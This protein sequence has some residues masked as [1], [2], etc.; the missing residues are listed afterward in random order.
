MSTE[1]AE[2]YSDLL[3]GLAGFSGRAVL[4]RHFSVGVGESEVQLLTDLGKQTGAIVDQ[5]PEVLPEAVRT[6][7]IYRILLGGKDLQ[8]E[9]GHRQLL[10]TIAPNEEMVK[11]VLDET[12]NNISAAIEKTAPDIKEERDGIRHK[13]GL[14][15]RAHLRDRLVSIF[16]NAQFHLE[17]G[18]SFSP[19]EVREAFKRIQILVG[20]EA[21]PR[22]KASTA[23]LYLLGAIPE[24]EILKTPTVRAVSSY[25]QV[26]SGGTEL[27]SL[28]RRPLQPKEI[29]GYNVTSLEADIQESL[30]WAG[31]FIRDIMLSVRDLIRHYEATGQIQGE[32]NEAPNLNQ[33]LRNKS[34]YEILEYL[35][36]GD[37]VRD[38]ND[39][40]ILWVIGFIHFIQ[41]RRIQNIEAT[42]KV[43]DADAKILE[44]MFESQQPNQKMRYPTL[45]FT[46]KK[47]EATGNG[48]IL[49]CRKLRTARSVAEYQK[50]VHL[51]EVDDKMEKSRVYKYFGKSYGDVGPDRF[52]DEI[53]T[54]GILA[55]ITSTEL[56]SDEELQNMV[57]ENLVATAHGLGM[58]TNRTAELE[59]GT[60]KP[61]DL[62]PGQF[63][64]EKDFKHAR[65]PKISLLGVTKKGVRVE[66]MLICVDTHAFEE[67]DG[68]G[69]HHKVK[70]RQLEFKMAKDLAP[71]SISLITHRVCNWELDRIEILQKATGTAR[72]EF[73]AKNP[74]FFRQAA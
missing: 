48:A 19:L 69:M 7:D 41:N 1:G 16:K 43:K 23:V 49:S 30:H 27:S 11:T 64:I 55:G 34:P 17:G 37:D 21:L 10:I 45:K 59:A 24:T 9:L 33:S 29:Q 51:V 52:P 62:E 14:A 56:E 57:Y 60:L 72:T 70:E 58:E 47:F 73:L 61:T 54:R 71:Q 25:L 36:T 74:E 3:Q 5:K 13:I 28:L 20:K 66:V 4:G 53:R 2:D 46:G 65:Y 38:V 42:N 15:Q 22:D 18:R 68:S 50:L 8:R 40:Q 12:A 67:A 63:V 32:D 31:D 35:Y 6:N 44:N 39:A 26:H